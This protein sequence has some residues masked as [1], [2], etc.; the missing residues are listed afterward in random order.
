LLLQCADVAMYD[1]KKQGRNCF[2]L[3][4]GAMNLDMVNRQ[5]LQSD[6]KKAVANNE[7]LLLYQPII[8]LV[9]GTMNSMESLLRWQHPQLGLLTPDSFLPVAKESGLISE[10]DK[11]M[12][13]KVCAQLKEWREKGYE[14]TVR[15]NVA[16]RDF[17]SSD[18][19]E[20][21]FELMDSGEMDPAMLSVE[22]EESVLRN[23]APQ[24]VRNLYK[25]KESPVSISI[26][27]FGTEYASLVTLMRGRIQY[28][29]I[30]RSYFKSD[31]AYSE[32]FRI[33]QALIV[34]MAHSLNVKVIAA[35]VET[36]AQLEF[37]KKI[38]CDLA[39]GYFYYKPMYSNEIEELLS[40]NPTL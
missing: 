34:A 21:F 31:I 4:S 25:L 35:G 10:I 15:I 16:L 2:R 38:G 32:H 30:D 33:I 29:K 13:L 9:T 17:L 40:S 11:L 20:L 26:D 23:D 28:V 1:A 27:N 3:F 12:L 6:L 5:Q 18:F 19:F 37:L 24:V 22:L 14:V 36:E 7:F 39:Q 8:D